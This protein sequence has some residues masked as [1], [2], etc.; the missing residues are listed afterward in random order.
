[1]D[2]GFDISHSKKPGREHGEGTLSASFTAT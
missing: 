2:R 1:M